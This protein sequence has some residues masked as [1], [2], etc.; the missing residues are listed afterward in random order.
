MKEKKI[1]YE[2]KK[3][4]EEWRTSPLPEINQE[5]YGNVAAVELFKYV[6]KSSNL[7][8]ASKMIVIPDGKGGIMDAKVAL[9]MR[10]L[11]IARIIAVGDAFDTEERGN[12][13]DI[14]CVP[15]TDIL[16]PDVPHP[17]YLMLM[18]MSK[19]NAKPI[20]PEGL[21][22][23]ISSLE[24]K[25]FQYAYYDPFDFAAHDEETRIFII[26]SIKITGKWNG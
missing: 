13:G 25:W 6:P 10:F 5:P 15:S 14:V 26:P 22:E 23:K 7:V 16:G 24:K 3:Q 8:G 9:N 20:I 4:F 18:Q 2:V 12:V 11:P 1:N 17:D 19:S 21:R